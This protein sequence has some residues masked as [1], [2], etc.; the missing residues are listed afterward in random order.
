[1][2]AAAA[3]SLATALAM[4]NLIDELASMSTLARYRGFAASHIGAR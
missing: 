3:I 2:L 4:R 1:M